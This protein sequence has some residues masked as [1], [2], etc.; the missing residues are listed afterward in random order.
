MPV[1]TEDGPSIKPDPESSQHLQPMDEDDDFED[2]GE[3]ELPPNAEEAWLLRVPR[4]LH[5]KWSSVNQ[6]EEIC[7]GRIR[8]GKSSGKVLIAIPPSMHSTH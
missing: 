7:I 6:D 1:K 2:T 5:E 3:L 4:V 8:K